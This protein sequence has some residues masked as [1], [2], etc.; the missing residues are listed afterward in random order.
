MRQIE[1]SIDKWQKFSEKNKLFR[2]YNNF[3]NN[4]WNNFNRFSSLFNIHLSWSDK[5]IKSINNVEELN[6]IDALYGLK[7]FYLNISTIKPD[8]SHPEI[9]QCYNLTAI[10]NNFKIKEIYFKENIDVEI[11]DP[12]GNVTGKDNHVIM[13]SLSK[14]QEITI[15]EI[16][17]EIKAIEEFERSNNKRKSYYEKKSNN[18]ILKKNKKVDLE[19][20]IDGK[21]IKVLEDIK[22]RNLKNDLLILM[23]VIKSINTEKPNLKNNLIRKIYIQMVKNKSSNKSIFS[24]IVLPK[25]TW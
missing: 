19:F 12:F 15:N 9:L 16:K 1:D 13:E 6:V 18:I 24:R 7:K 10:K 3:K 23:K 14:F 5:I 17:K 25:Y 11:L 22:F 4:H 21:K 2:N 8:L 20:Y